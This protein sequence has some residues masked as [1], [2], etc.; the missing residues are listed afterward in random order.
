MSSA[1]SSTPK[2]SLL[3]FGDELRSK[4]DQPAHVRGD[5]IR[6]A[7]HSRFHKGVRM[8]RARLVISTLGPI[9]AVVLV[10]TST[11]IAAD[12]PHGHG[13]FD[14]VETTIPAIQQAIQDNI[15]SADQLVE[16]YHTRIAA[17]DGKDTATHLNSYIH[18]NEGAV[19]DARQHG[20]GHA[21]GFQKN[22][23]L[24]GIPIILKD[25]VDTKDM[26]TTAGSVAFAGSVPTSD[27]FV[28]RKLMDAG[29]IVL[30]KATM[31]EF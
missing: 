1:D 25:N 9:A 7:N 12:N 20:G 11:R 10:S 2:S 21:P 6:P 5:T 31:T 14:L 29:A 17:Y 24:F 3:C 8:K 15:I 4:K 26:P 19:K 23:P 13:R 16:M 28:A 18:L 22:H 30:G 27:A